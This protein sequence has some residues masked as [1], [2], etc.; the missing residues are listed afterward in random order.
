MSDI[1]VRSADL[2]VLAG[3]LEQLNKRLDLGTSCNYLRGALDRATTG[4]GGLSEAVEHFEN[5]WDYGRTRIA[6][7]LSTI[8]SVLRHVAET[9]EQAERVLSGEIDRAVS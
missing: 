3:D 7:S 6:G 5:E 1:R 4:H 9:Y 2:R 8:V